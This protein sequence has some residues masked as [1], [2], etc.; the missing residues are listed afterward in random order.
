MSKLNSNWGLVVGLGLLPMLL[1]IDGGTYPENQARLS[2]MSA[3]Q[4]E[5]L[6]RKKSSFDLLSPQEQDRLR[7]LDRAIHAEPNAEHLIQ[8]LRD[9]QEWLSSFRSVEQANL[10]DMPNDKRIAEMKSLIS[11]VMTSRT[12]SK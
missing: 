6:W 5:Q 10:Q 8:T 2:A 3:E 12:I 4:L 9:Y 1:A 7:R 11:L